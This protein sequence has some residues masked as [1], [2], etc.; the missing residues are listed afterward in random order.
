[1]PPAAFHLQSFRPIRD[2]H[3]NR[4]TIVTSSCSRLAPIH[5]CMSIQVITVGPAVKLL[6]ILHS[7]QTHHTP[8]SQESTHTP[9]P[10][11]VF[12]LWVGT[13]AGAETKSLPC[14]L[15]S[16]NPVCRNMRS[17][18]VACC[19]RPTLHQWLMKFHI[20]LR[21]HSL[22]ISLLGLYAYLR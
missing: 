19:S 21:I 22:P 2:A 9:A 6:I 14:L 3:L 12:I 15:W 4:V 5:W 18:N 11:L 20:Y 8:P 7:L 10:P 17:K 16:C 13:H 1:M